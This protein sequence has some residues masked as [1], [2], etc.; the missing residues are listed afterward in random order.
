MA[1]Q[2]DNPLVK[3]LSEKGIKRSDFADRLGV[4]PGRVSQICQAGISHIDI[5]AKIEKAT[6]GE[7]PVSAWQSKEAAQ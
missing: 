2:P 6:D 5:A 3:W 4:T 7:I 1:D